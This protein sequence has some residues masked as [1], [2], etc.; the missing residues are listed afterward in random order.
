MCGQLSSLFT[1]KSRRHHG[2]Q[3]DAMLHFVRQLQRS[4]SQAEGRQNSVIPV[5]NFTLV[6]RFEDVFYH[7][8]TDNFNYVSRDCRMF[9]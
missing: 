7:I 6:C 2:G 5:F 8:K 9:T 3:R 1:L 4:L